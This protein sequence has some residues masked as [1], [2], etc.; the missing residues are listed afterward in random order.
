MVSDDVWAT[1]REYNRDYYGRDL[2]PEIRQ[3]LPD[4]TEITTFDGGV[5]VSKG[6][7]FDLFVVPA[8]RGRWRIRSEITK[9]LRKLGAKH[10]SLIV[11][12]NEH[13]AKSLRLAKFFGFTE[14]SRKDKII[15]LEST[16]WAA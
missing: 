9:F 4:L 16:S 2:T 5:F 8:K 15:Q 3:A 14:I 11:N 7:E 13:N 6:N 10:N 1:M 12:I